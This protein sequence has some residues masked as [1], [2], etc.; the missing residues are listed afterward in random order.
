MFQSAARHSKWKAR[1]QAQQRI[2]LRSISFSH[3]SHSRPTTFGRRALAPPGGA[4][5]PCCC[6]PGHS[7]PSLPPC[8]SASLPSALPASVLPSLLAPFPVRSV[9]P[10]APK[11]SSPTLPSSSPLPLSSPWTSLSHTAP[12]SR[13]SS[14]SSAPS[15]SAAAALVLAGP[16]RSSMGATMTRRWGGWGTLV[17]AP[18]LAYSL[19]RYCSVSGKKH[20]GGTASIACSSAILPLSPCILRAPSSAATPLTAFDLVGCCHAHSNWRAWT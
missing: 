2:T 9:S 3:R 14:P 5:C 8:P 12:S 20:Q 16:G 10:T 11:G 19:L 1:L 15:S 7:S 17:L 13:S 6:N 18:R 4:C